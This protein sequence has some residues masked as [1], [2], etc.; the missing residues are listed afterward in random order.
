MDDNHDQKVMIWLI[1]MSQYT[2][3]IERHQYRQTQV[4][5]WIVAFIIVYGLGHIFLVVLESVF[6]T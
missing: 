1:N 4:V 6:V 2:F 5:S 3:I